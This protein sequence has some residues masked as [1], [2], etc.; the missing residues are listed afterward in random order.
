MMRKQKTIL[1]CLSILSFF[2][3]IFMANGVSLHLPRWLDWGNRDVTVKMERI[4][5][6]YSILGVIKVVNEYLWFAIGFICFL[7]TIINWYKL[8]TAQWDE[9]QMKEATNALIWCAIWIAVCLLSYI[10][11]NLA[12][13]LFA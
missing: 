8:I 13:R 1:T 2:V 5:W 3:P 12:L 9:K 11:V 7:F 6:S 10:I 4:D